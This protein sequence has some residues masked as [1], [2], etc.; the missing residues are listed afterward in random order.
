MMSGH[1]HAAPAETTELD[2]REKGMPIDGEP[3]VCDQRLYGQL[4]AF[5]GCTDPDALVAPLQASGLDVVLY[6][7]VNDPYGVGVAIFTTEEDDLTGTARS[8]FQT[9]EFRALTPKPQFTMLGRTYGTGREENLEDWLLRKPRRSAMNPDN[10]WAVWYPL[11]RTGE[12][13]SLDKRAQ[14]QILGEHGRKGAPYAMQGYAADIRLAC[15]GIDANDNDFV[16]GL[17]G[18][19]LTPLSKLVQDMRSTTQTSQYIESLGPF[20]VGKIHWAA[21]Y[22]G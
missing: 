19:E 2:L 12:F 1:P 16:I 6:L 10:P 20:F 13:N 5:G 8:I 15:H 9:D 14:G 21:D 22:H 4:F 17:T 11:R 3:Q 18:P 7:D